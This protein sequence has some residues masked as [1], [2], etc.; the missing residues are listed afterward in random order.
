LKCCWTDPHPAD[1]D[2][3]TSP[4]YPILVTIDAAGA[5]P[6]NPI[7]I[8]YELTR[9]EVTSMVR[10][11]LVHVAHFRRHM[12]T[13]LVIVVFALVLVLSGGSE[14][15][16]AGGILL[17]IGLLTLAMLG[18]LYFVAVPG[19]AWKASAADGPKVM[20]FTDEGV[21]SRSRN[22][23]ATYRWNT[24][25]VA[26]ELPLTYL[27]RHRARKNLYTYVPKRAFRSSSDESTFR[28]LA[29]AYITIEHQGP[30]R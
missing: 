8:E 10:W 18:L 24:Y 29:A 30:S 20:E 19:Q 28:G 3:L 5:G 17:G 7:T 21:H 13:V 6:A 27:L 11:T 12:V 23:D 2:S 14:N 4:N 25:S 26:L 16:I 22:T 1:W 15:A 9:E